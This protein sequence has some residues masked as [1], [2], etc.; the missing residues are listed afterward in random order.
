MKKIMIVEDEDAICNELSELLE[1]NNYKAIILKD[2]KNALNEILSSSPN[3]ILLDINIPYINGEILLQDLRKSSNIPV[4]MVTSNNSETDEA[5]SISYGADDYITKPYNPNILLLRIGAVLKRVN[6]ESNI[7]TYKDLSINIGK[8]IIKRDD[9]EII[10]TKNEMIIFS[11]LLNHQ[12]KIVTRDELMTDLWNNEEFINDNA[13]TVNI[14]RLRAKL[15]NIGYEDAIDT[16]K[17][18]G[19]ILS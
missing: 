9:M 14:S 7:L 8:G 13:L 2:F 11:Y 18:M 4:I 5:L 15:K 6:N 17:G 3:L 16:R 10:L 19:Y 12:N 1:N